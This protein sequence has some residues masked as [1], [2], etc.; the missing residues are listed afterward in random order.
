MG[1]LTYNQAAVLAV[2]SQRS[3]PIEA[4]TIGES[5]RTMSRALERKGST[6]VSALGDLPLRGYGRN[7]G[8]FYY[9][10][11]HGTIKS[12][13]RSGLVE[14]ANDRRKGAQYRL[15]PQ[16]LTEAEPFAA[17]VTGVL[18]ASWSS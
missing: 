14:K 13:V 18:G 4:R 7:Y 3:S 8:S 2:L 1:K 10:R 17:A 6:I 5:V 15:T 12:L 9:D 16:G 11:A